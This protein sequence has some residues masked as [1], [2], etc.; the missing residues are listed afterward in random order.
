MKPMA[1]LHQGNGICQFA[2]AKNPLD[3]FNNGQF[4]FGSLFLKHFYSI[5]DYDQE[6]ISLGVNEHSKNLVSMKQWNGEEN[7]LKIK[8]DMGL[9]NAVKTVV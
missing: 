2:I 5:Y 7:E 1:Y 9:K 8:A 6:Y 3:N 4:L